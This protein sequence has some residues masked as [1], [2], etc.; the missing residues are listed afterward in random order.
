M[1]KARPVVASAVGGIVDQIV[2][3]ESGLLVRDPADLASFGRAVSM[4]LQDPELAVRLAENAQRRACEHY[5]ADRHLLQYAALLGRL[6][7]D[8]QAGGEPPSP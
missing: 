6:F 2:D 5:L 8:P 7:S 4:V 3:G 1:L